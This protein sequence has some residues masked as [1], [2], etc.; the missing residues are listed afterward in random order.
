MK[1]QTTTH[2][3]PSLLTFHSTNCT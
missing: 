1:P 3:L 2:A